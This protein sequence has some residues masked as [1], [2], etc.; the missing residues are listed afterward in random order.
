LTR[1][2]VNITEVASDF[3]KKNDYRIT[4][5]MVVESLNIPETVVLWI[6]KEIFCSLDFFLLRDNAHAHKAASVC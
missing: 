6:L 4:S 3:F 1:T 5:R 2:E